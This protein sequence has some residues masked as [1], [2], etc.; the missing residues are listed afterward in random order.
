[1]KNKSAAILFGVS[2]IFCAASSASNLMNQNLGTTA[3]NH[4]FNSPQPRG[5]LEDK[6]AQAQQ[7]RGYF[8]LPALQQQGMVKRL[9]RGKV[10]QVIALQQDFAVVIAT[11]GATLFNLATGE[12]LWEI[13]CPANGGA[14][15]ADQRLLALYK[16]K[17]I[18]L[19]DLTTG[20]FLHQFFGHTGDVNSISFSPD[21]QTLASGS[22]T[23]RLW[24]VATGEELRQFTG[25]IDWVNSVSFSPD[26]KYLASGGG[27]NT[28]RLWDVATGE[29]LRQFTG[30][31]SSVSSVS[32]SP[33]GKTLASG[34]GGDDKTVRLWDV[35]TGQE[36]RQ[37]SG[38]T[39]AIFS[40]DGKYLASET[41]D[42]V[43]L[44][45]VATGEELRQFQG[46]TWSVSSISFSP[47]G[48]YLVSGSACGSHNCDP[49]ARLW[50]VATGKEIRQF[51]GHPNGVCCVSFSPD[52]K[53][54]VSGGCGD[55]YFEGGRDGTV[56]LWDVATGQELRQF[57][58]HE[59]MVR[60]VAFSPEG[61]YLASGS[62][63]G[64]VRLWD[65]GD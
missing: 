23:V 12:D 64:T 36:L 61:K 62:L 21:G 10:R 54:L 46:H 3:T 35:A 39:T 4:D 8:T 30:D 27:D 20:Q 56:R 40:P 7:L 25:D 58:G 60:S 14:V 22:D 50:D 2:L 52:G 5:L 49:V 31:A 19:W 32:F 33:D 55:I 17:D 1:M 63:D 37:F 34:S 26:G 6:I 45:D 43:R 65:I 29:E 11:G 16:D 48:K 41:G 47:D 59:S 38:D 18:Y 15:S 42:E 9:G 51:T 57:T 24:D 53:Y 28:V 44:W 13:D